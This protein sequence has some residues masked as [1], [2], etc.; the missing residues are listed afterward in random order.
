MPVTLMM[1]DAYASRVRDVL[2]PLSETDPML[3]GVYES[4]Q[5]QLEAYDK[6]YVTPTEI[7]TERK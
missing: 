2:R 4:L 6:V 1:T 5:Q 7:V 3:R